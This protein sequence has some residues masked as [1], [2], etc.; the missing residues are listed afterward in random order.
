V[1]PRVEMEI[2]SNETI[3]QAVAAGLGIGFLSAHAVRNEVEQGT[4]VIVDVQGFPVMRLWYVVRRSERQLPRIAQAFEGF[5][6]LRGARLI[7][8]T[9]TIPFKRKAR[10]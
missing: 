2:T 5:L 7:G 10:K 1:A 8:E 9:P 4:L 3:K 6:V